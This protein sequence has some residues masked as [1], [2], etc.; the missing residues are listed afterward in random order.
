MSSK[1]KFKRYEREFSKLIV[2]HKIPKGTKGAKYTH[3]CF[4]PPWGTYNI[5][6]EDMHQFLDLY[7]KL[8]KRIDFHFTEK[9]TH[10][11]PLCIDIDFKFA[12][13]YKER[14][15]KAKTIK[16]LVSRINKRITEYYGV[17]EDNVQAF[18]FEKDTPSHEEKSNTY[19]D[20]FHIMYPYIPMET[21]MR[22]YIIDRVR[23]DVTE[24]GD[25]G[26][27]PFMNEM[28]DVFDTCVVARNGRMMYGSRKHQKQLYQLTKVYDINCDEEDLDDIKNN[29]LPKLL[30]VR[31]FTEDDI[32]PLKGVTESLDFK[33]RMKYTI[34]KYEGGKSSYNMEKDILK[35]GIIK[36]IDNDSESGSDDDYESDSEEIPQD[37]EE[38]DGRP[39]KVK[40]SKEDVALA[41]KLVKILSVKKRAK[42]YKEWIYLGWCLH[43]IDDSL[44][45]DWI[46][47]SKKSPKDFQKGKCEE[48]WEQA[49]DNGGKL[50]IASLHHWAK[51][52]NPDKYAELMR[53]GVR[54]I[55]MEAENG[56]HYDVAMVIH[57][58][59]GHLFVCS[60]I[61][62]KTWYEFQGHRWVQIDSGHTLSIKISEELTKEFCHLNSYYYKI[63]PTREFA[64]RDDLYKKANTV[65]KLIDNLKKT[66]FKNS[67]MEQ[68]MHKF[69]DGEFES[70][71][72]ENKDLIGFENGV[73][74]LKEGYF[75]SGLP[76]DYLTFST[77]YKYKEYDMDHRYI[78]H[79]EDF[80]KKVQIERDMKDYLLTLFSSHLD[81]HNKQ[82]RFI[83][84]TGFGGCHSKGTKVIMS[85]GKFKNVE[86][87]QVGDTIMGDDS[88]P[89]TVK[90][91]FTG[92]DDM[93]KITNFKGETYIVNSEH[94]LALKAV[95]KNHIS[96]HQKAGIYRVDWHELCNGIPT[97]KSKRFSFK[98]HGNEDSAK[99]AA[100]KFRDDNENDNK[101][102]IRKGDVIPVKIVDYLKIPQN[103][104]RLY[105]GYKTGVEFKGND[106]QLD[107]YLL[108]YWLGDG[109][110]ECPRITTADK[111][112]V[113]KLS[114]TVSQYGLEFN[115]VGSTSYNYDITTGKSYTAKKGANHVRN[116]LKNLNLIN[117][118]HIPD[119]YMVNDRETRLQVLA[120]LI[121]S[122]GHY[123]SDMGN[124]EIIQKNQ[125]LAENIRDLSRSLGFGSSMNEC[126]KVCTN[127]KDGPKEGTYYRVMIYGDMED[128]PC[129]L[130]R[131]QYSH[132]KSKKTNRDYLVSSIKVEPAGK[133]NYYGFEITGNHRYVMKDYTV[134]YNSNGKSTA[135]DFLMKAMGDY[136]SVVP[137]TMLTR[138][139]GSSS[140]PTP[141]LADKR[142]VRFIQIN[143]PSGDDKID[144]GYMK[145]L[146]GNDLILAR[147]MY[148]EPF[149]FRPQF[150]MILIC[151]ILPYI[152]S[153]DGGTWRRLRVTPWDSKFVDLD[154]K[155][156]GKNQFYKDPEINQKME[157]WKA[158]FMWLMLKK[159]YPIYREAGGM[160]KEPAKVKEYTNKYKADSDVYYEYLDEFYETTSK[161]KDVI[162]FIDVYKSFVN[163]HREAYYGGGSCPSKKEFKN[164]LINNNY[165]LKGSKLVGIKEKE[166]NEDEGMENEMNNL[167][168]L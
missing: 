150:K 167:D 94:R 9:P 23:E 147:Q 12:S 137:H 15:Y 85:D 117:N 78:D 22:Y 108:G 5:P 118:K 18:V 54:S 20:G 148:K 25:F 29:N 123:S 96:Y 129:I 122:D 132:T 44:L 59:Y 24:E 121:D 113:D 71:L 41:R 89:R 98:E 101:K 76:D 119:E 159:Y 35:N 26:D 84:F 90:E 149:Y 16:K 72:D 140:G 125:T 40:G 168:E 28:S 47:F 164:Y 92:Y 162:S 136:A 13:I 30:S 70:K 99:L 156:E 91:L 7:N 124:Y 83:L 103:T 34:D 141:E 95:G 154:E 112:V 106:V 17:E 37:S 145:E 131:K 60:S 11:A 86:D 102:L 45:Q 133:D 93:Y 80:F 10:V 163:W 81:G 97:Y 57:A 67:V 79:V 58:L 143:E 66:G 68:C 135:V 73:Y 49:R 43:N 115:K 155:L 116:C 130:E 36:F 165:T 46:A 82:Q 55:L 65:K 52:D 3:T 111:E 126:K 77:G 87:V 69:Y 21:K 104:R 63:A 142:G 105:M 128:I 88:T 32:V 62:Y 31:K 160:V 74:D 53:D 50:T 51:E 33:L 48:V 107:P 152:P 56:H 139:R 4:G 161:S 1:S 75:R 110:S 151:N 42:K 6:E 61:K 166:I 158:A 134:T 2:K 157:K 19:K 109:A 146:S 120:G 153:T 64:E 8:Y 138:K 27:I 14:T 38:G 114:D 100:E 39:P 144:V 127:A